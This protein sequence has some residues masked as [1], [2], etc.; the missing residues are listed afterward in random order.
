MHLE[1]VLVKPLLTEKSSIETEKTNRYVFKVQLKANKYQVRD[2]VEKMFD[3]KVVDV[4]TA[5]L[6][7]KVKRAGKTTKKTSSWKKAYVKIQ[8]GQKLELFKGI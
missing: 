2:A 8:E 1:Q 7:G 5:V 3:V 4:K 6:P